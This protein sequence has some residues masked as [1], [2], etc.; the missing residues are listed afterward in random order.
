LSFV[1]LI[2]PPDKLYN[3]AGA[4]LLVYPTEEIQDV[5][6]KILLTSPIDTNIYIY[7]INNDEHHYDWLLDVHK[8]SNVCIMNLDAFPNELKCL[9]SYLISFCNTYYITQG[10]NILYSKISQNHIY[11]L[12]RIETLIKESL[13]IQ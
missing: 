4:I 2:T 11:S 12:D 9:E 10:D 5:L 6:Q 13:Q 3:Q 7:N 1:N 8:F